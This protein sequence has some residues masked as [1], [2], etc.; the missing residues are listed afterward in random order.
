MKRHEIEES[1]KIRPPHVNLSMGTLQNKK[2]EGT[3]LKRDS[4][5]PKTERT[6]EENGDEMSNKIQPFVS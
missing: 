6:T 5:V 3:V 1:G 2:E 4:V